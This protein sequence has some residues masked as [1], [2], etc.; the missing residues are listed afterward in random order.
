MSNFAIVRLEKVKNTESFNG[1]LSHNNRSFFTKN[2]DKTRTNKNII[3]TKSIYK[4]I[5]EFA[6]AKRT[7]I[8]E[9]NLKHGTKHRMLRQTTDK[10]TSKKEYKSMA[11]E[12]VISTSHLALNDKQSIEYLK[13]ADTFLR[14]H[15]ENCEVIQSVIHLDEKTPH[16]HFFVSYFDKKNCKFSQEELRSENKTDVDTIRDLFQEEVAK[17]FG[18]KKQDG[19]VITPNEWTQANKQ[20]GELKEK[21][22]T[23]EKSNNKLQDEVKELEFTISSINKKD[24]NTHSTHI[25]QVN[26]TQLTSYD[27]VKNSINKVVNQE[28]KYIPGVNKVELNEEV[29][30]KPYMDDYNAVIEENEELKIDYNILIEDIE[31]LDNDLNANTDTNNPKNLFDWIKAKFKEFKEKISNLEK[32]IFNI[33]SENIQLRVENNQLKIELANSTQSKEQ[34]EKD[35][36]NEIYKNRKSII[37]KIKK[38]KGR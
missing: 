8:R 4:N 1:R 12:L 17:P 37:S 3:L 26:N 18:L 11:Q 15:F 5:D 35:T 19:S 14:E 21:Y 28:K 38:L 27:I 30:F 34:I 20:I 24:N 23:V 25:T 29:N 36:I 22:K 9:Y 32:K 31:Y 16:L 6:D 33:E 10:K 7:Q 2:I 13:K